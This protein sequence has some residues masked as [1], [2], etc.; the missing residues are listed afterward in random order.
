LPVPSGELS[1]AIKM[2]ASGTALRVR[3]MM[4]AM[5]SDSL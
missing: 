2:W 4:R 5:F 1:S 3:L